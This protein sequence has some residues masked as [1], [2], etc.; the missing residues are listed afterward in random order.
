VSLP[1]LDAA[2]TDLSPAAAA[3]AATFAGWLATRRLSAR[4]R[5]TYAERA[6][7]FLGWLDA[8]GAGFRG[9]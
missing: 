3:A 5:A 7:R 9:G 2:V 1:A 6:G 8:G 4:T